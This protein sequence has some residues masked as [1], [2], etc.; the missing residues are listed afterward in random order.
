MRVSPPFFC[1]VVLVSAVGPSFSF[2]RFHAC[3]C[4]HRWDAECLNARMAFQHRAFCLNSRSLPSSSSSRNSARDR[5]GESSGLLVQNDSF[6]RQPRASTISLD[7]DICRHPDKS[8]V[9]A[10]IS[11]A[12][13]DQRAPFNWMIDLSRALRACRCAF[14]FGFCGLF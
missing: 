13:V 11:Y 9:A 12:C 2:T 1:I 6:Y 8:R 10:L 3:G 5:S 4:K 7:G 14:I